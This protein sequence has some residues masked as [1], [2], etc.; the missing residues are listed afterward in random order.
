MANLF[1]KFVLIAAL[2]GV[3]SSTAS[4]APS[5]VDRQF[6][7]QRNLLGNGGAESGKSQWSASSGTFTTTTTA[8]NV[9]EGAASFSWDAS[10]NGQTLSAEL[11]TV[12][13]GYYGRDGVASCAIKAASSTAAYKLQVYDGTNVIAEKTMT[14][15][16]TGF[17][18]TTLNFVTPSTGSYRIRL[19]S[20]QDEP[21]IYVDSCY[22]GLAEGFNTYQVS[23]ASFVGSAYIGYNAT[24]TN[25]V[26]STSIVQF[27]TAAGCPAPVVESNPGPGVIQT[28]DADGP[29]F[30]VA[31][32]PPGVYRVEI[33]VPVGTSGNVDGMIAI[34]DG[35][36]TSTNTYIDSGGTTVV[37]SFAA[38]GMFSYTS[39]GDRTFK[40]YGAVSSGTLTAYTNKGSQKQQYRFRIYRFPSTSE[41]AFRPDVMP[42]SWSGYHANNCEWS[43]TSTSYVDP[44]ADASCTFTEATNTN[45]GTVTS[46]GSTQPNINWTPK[47][48]GSYYVCATLN[49]YSVSVSNYGWLKLTDGTTDIAERGAYGDM[50]SMALCGIYN[51]TSL[52][53]KTLKIQLKSVGSSTTALTGNAV[54]RAIDWSIFYI[55]QGV[56]T[57]TLVGSVTSNS[58]GAERVERV[59]ISGAGACAVVAQSGSWVS[60]VTHNATGDCTLTIAA[61]MFSAA[62]TCTC[63]V[64]NAA[65]RY[66]AGVGSNTSTSIR[67]ATKTYADV[68]QDQ[69]FDVI[70]VGPK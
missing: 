44:A 17:V 21:I 36:T 51:V 24:C 68:A 30:T 40:L 50:S 41:M 11:L 20:T 16:T 69:P 35:T 28:T 60:G 22:L 45:F 59:Q 63:T 23:Q 9:Y 5:E 29:T 58:T 49:K 39:A 46:S 43:T 57:P 2:M 38:V 27:S 3:I 13:Q 53:S 55:S 12:P 4:A 70:C 10:A 7:T 19:A 56:Q 67:F 25:T 42:A 18:R 15:S 48:I 31:G 61:G 54:G 33:E 14:V 37:H 66:C 34:N 47:A 32:L 6:Y 65:S 52:S 8:A 62:P 26:T 64:T 1:K